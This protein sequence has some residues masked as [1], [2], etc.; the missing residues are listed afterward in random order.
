M[1]DKA[2]VIRRVKKLKE[3]IRYATNPMH[4]AE[5]R[6]ELYTSAQTLARIED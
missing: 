1:S 6:R 2:K 4:E 5:L 3:D